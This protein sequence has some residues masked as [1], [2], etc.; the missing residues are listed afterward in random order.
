MKSM[1]KKGNTISTKQ[2]LESCITQEN[3]TN[4]FQNIMENYDFL[5][6]PST[7]SAAPT[8]N[9]S[10]KRHIINLDFF[11]CSFNIFTNILL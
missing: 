9:K 1:I 7:G 5:V 3:L 10:E 6:T 8:L 4:K 11:W 2:Y